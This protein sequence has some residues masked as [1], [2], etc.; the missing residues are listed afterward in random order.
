MI[1][2]AV[3]I[4]FTG[5]H[6]V[7]WY[8]CYQ[9]LKTRGVGIFLVGSSVGD[10]LFGEAIS[11]VFEGRVFYK[12]CENRPLGNKW[13]QACQF[14][15]SSRPSYLLIN[16]SDDLVSSL[17]LTPQFLSSFENTRHVMCG[18]SNWSILNIGQRRRDYMELFR[19]KYLLEDSTITI[20]A[21]RLYK[22]KWLD[23]IDWKIFEPSL[24]VRLDDLGGDLAK[25]YGIHEVFDPY[26]ILSLKG[27]WSAMNSLSVILGAQTVESHNVNYIEK[28]RILSKYFDC[29]VIKLTKRILWRNRKSYFSEMVF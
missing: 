28:N 17:Y 29:D 23:S 19:C 14:A 8:N 20:G 11:K 4:A 26:F 6:E 5:R 18:T 7:L 21:G 27:P 15:R 13:L 16:G 3:A 12:N 22:S 24:E 10:D 1:N 2:I 25:D 9:L